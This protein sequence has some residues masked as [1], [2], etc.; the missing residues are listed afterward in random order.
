MNTTQQSGKGETHWRVYPEESRMAI[1]L[2]RG[3]SLQMNVQNIIEGVLFSIPN[4]NPD[5][6]TIRISKAGHR[7]VVES[8]TEEEIVFRLEPK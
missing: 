5:A 1:Y 2:Y 8:E 3:D 6:P 7:I 4:D